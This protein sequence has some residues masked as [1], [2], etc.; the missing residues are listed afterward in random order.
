MNSWIVAYLDIPVENF[1]PKTYLSEELEAELPYLP[2]Y[3]TYERFIATVKRELEAELDRTEVAHYEPM[4]EFHFD[5]DLPADEVRRRLAEVP[6]L[7]DFAS[8][9][10]MVEDMAPE[11][12]Y[13]LELEQIELEL[14]QAQAEMEERTAR[15]N[16]EGARLAARIGQRKPIEMVDEAAEY[17]DKSRAS[18]KRSTGP[19]KP[20]SAFGL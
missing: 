5:T 14:A 15:W 9:V 3:E 4:V 1:D 18:K 13:A 7:A 6:A 19:S 11:R 16:E 8:A 2:F 20:G 17:I 12:E 10:A